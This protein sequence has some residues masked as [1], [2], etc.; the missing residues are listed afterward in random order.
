MAPCYP[1]DVLLLLPLP[2]LLKLSN[3]L[4]PTPVDGKR[5]GNVVVLAP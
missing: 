1:L 3:T 5:K 4:I 2:D